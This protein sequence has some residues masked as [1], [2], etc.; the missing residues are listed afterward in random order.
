MG[1]TRRP[2][3]VLIQSWGLCR[4]FKVTFQPTLI[5]L[6][7]APRINDI[8]LSGQH[9]PMGPERGRFLETVSPASK[10]VASRCVPALQLD[11]GQL[12]LA[13]HGAPLESQL[14]MA[15]F[16]FEVCL[17][18]LGGSALLQAEQTPSLTIKVKS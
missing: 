2:F 7:E 16:C 17:Q 5:T 14:V 1:D 8:A 6:V 18:T 9:W 10:L 15:T 4:D 13:H 12:L 3:S 11:L